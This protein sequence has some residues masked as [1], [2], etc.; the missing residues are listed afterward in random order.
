MTLRALAAAAILASTAA[1]PLSAAA[2]TAVQNARH[3]GDPDYATRRICRVTG[4]IGTRLGRNRVCKT[5]AE[6]DE[7]RRDQRNMVEAFQAFT[8]ACMTGSNAPGGSAVV[9][10][11]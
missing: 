4:T 5:R 7:F 2:Q 8:P 1:A 3:T 9:C 10:G 11:N 6:W